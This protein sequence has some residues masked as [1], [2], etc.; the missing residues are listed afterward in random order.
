MTATAS[1]T[2]TTLVTVRPASRALRRHAGGS[3]GSEQLIGWVFLTPFLIAFALFL[4]WPILH[5]LYLSFTDQ[6]LTGS[7][8]GLV[9]YGEGVPLEVR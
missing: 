4:V 7:G 8:G 3:Q 6:S 1:P 9:G 2:T 5:G